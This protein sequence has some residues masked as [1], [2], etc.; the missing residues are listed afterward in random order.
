[1]IIRE[2]AGNG[3]IIRERARKRYFSRFTRFHAGPFTRDPV[4]ST[5]PSIGHHHDSRHFLCSPQGSHH[6][7]SRLILCSPQ[8]GHHHDSRLFLCSPQGLLL[9][10]T[11]AAGLSCGVHRAFYWSSPWQQAYPVESTGPSIGHHH[12]SRLILCSPQGLL[13]VITMAAG[14]PC[15]VHRACY[16]PSPW[17][18]ALPVES[19]GPSIGHHHGSRHSLWSPQGLL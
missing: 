5:G 13:L 1:M 4:Q 12:G 11:M 7:G 14:T 10:I 18:Q 9:V 3:V 6:H 19:T 17:Q 16:R 15:G 8:G 2:R